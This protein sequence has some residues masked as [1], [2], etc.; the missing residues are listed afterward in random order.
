M[1]EFM[2]EIERFLKKLNEAVE[3]DEHTFTC[4][5]C[6]NEAHWS[7]ATGNGH[8]HCVCKGCGILMME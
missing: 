3:K 4:P 6:G 5:L 7:R 8:L 2:K 1:D